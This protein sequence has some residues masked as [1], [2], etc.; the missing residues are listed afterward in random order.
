[1]LS[2]FIRV[3]IFTT[4][5]FSSTCFASCYKDPVEL[6]KALFNSGYEFYAWPKPE[7][8]DTIA[9]PLS[10]AL[11]KE[12]KCKSEGEICAI[13]VDP[14]L[15]VQDGEAV[16][17]YEFSAKSTSAGTIL[18][19]FKFRLDLGEGKEV[20]IKSV[21]L[22]L[23]SSTKGCL[24]ITD[25]ISPGGGSLVKWLNEWHAKNNSNK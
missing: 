12:F 18:S 11:Q 25:F 5:M 3:S 4:A 2:R 22:S 7:F 17:P 13:D 6:T 1:M 21:Q 10:T 19:N 14:W 24:V 20:K 8:A 23:L 15:M 16:K 9:S